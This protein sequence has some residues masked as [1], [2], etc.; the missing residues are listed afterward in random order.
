MIKLATYRIACVCQ[1]SFV[2]V[3]N[4]VLIEV[5]EDYPIPMKYK[6]V[7]HADKSSY[8][9]FYIN[10]SGVAPSYYMLSVTCGIAPR[11]H[12][13]VRLHVAGHTLSPQE[14]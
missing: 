10:I 13:R 14:D 6:A 11:C 7:D 5:D 2:L 12:Q 3:Q 8:L 1:L 9:C 4:I